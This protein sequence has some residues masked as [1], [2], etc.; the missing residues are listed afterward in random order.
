MLLLWKLSLLVLHL[1]IWC[2][3][4]VVV[5]PFWNAYKLVCILS[6]VWVPA[7]GVN[8]NWYHRF[9]EDVFMA[10]HEVPNGQSWGHGFAALSCAG[11]HQEHVT[12]SRK[13]YRI[14]LGIT[15][16]D[17][18]QFLESHCVVYEYA[19]ET[20]HRPSPA[21]SKQK[22]FGWAHLDLV[23]LI[24]AFFEKPLSFF[25]IQIFNHENV[26]DGIA[27]ISLSFVPDEV[28]FNCASVWA[29]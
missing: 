22:L 8:T 23:N 6:Q 24:I 15:D 3:P 14:N 2:Y 4:P 11:H 9:A 7:S 10:V 20:V 29:S 21:V 26:L 5:A 16:G 13:L 19:R 27:Y 12:L 28:V 1:E 18:I 17:L 25:L